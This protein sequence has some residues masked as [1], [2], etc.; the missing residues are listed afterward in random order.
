[1]ELHP[2]NQIM[3]TH[4]NPTICTMFITPVH[5]TMAV[6]I[7]WSARDPHKQ[8]QPWS[9]RRFAGTVLLLFTVLWRAKYYVIY[10]H[11]PVQFLNFSKPFRQCH[12]LL[13]CMEHHSHSGM[14]AL[15]LGSVRHSQWSSSTHRHHILHGTYS[16]IWQCTSGI[17][18]KD[19][20]WHNIHLKNSLYTVT[21]IFR[22]LLIQVMCT[23]KCRS[24]IH[25]MQLRSHS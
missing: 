3:W 15:G 20:I 22:L 7:P 8:L 6:I 25:G 16:V 14:P 9:L 21:T 19:Q 4:C 13:C 17:W 12:L 2:F 10:L 11:K 1:M 5:I 18:N 23:F 24:D